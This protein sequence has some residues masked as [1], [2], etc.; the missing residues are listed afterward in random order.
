MKFKP[1]TTLVSIAALAAS[2]LLTTQFSLAQGDAA[3]QVEGVAEGASDVAAQDGTVVEGDVDAAVPALFSVGISGGFPS[4][5]T[6]ALSVSLQSSFVGLQ[7]KGSWTAA[8]PFL[9]LQLRGYPPVPVPVPL[10]LGVGVGIYG[11][12]VSYHGAV[13][14]HVPLSRALRLDLEGGL[15]SVPLLD[16]RSLAPHVAVGLS[17]AVPVA[18]EQNDG[19]G[20][21]RIGRTIAERSRSSRAAPACAEPR[22][23]ERGGV[24]DAVDRV[25]KEWLDSARATYGSVYTDL[26]YSYSISSSSVS[27]T[28]AT[29]SVS[30]RGSVRE[31]ATGRRHQ[32]SGTARAV[33]K[34]NGCAWLARDIS[35]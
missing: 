28:T 7:A 6:V 21:E 1:A 5:Q 20:G 31:I 16:G 13:G 17:Y 23:P 2:L 35:Y 30:Y 27:G 33:F 14:T 25:V 15:A 11:P 22:E 29:V 3:T 4:Y 8:G 12:N 34:W 9:G 32:A 24:G 19:D 26:N 18:I 10:Y